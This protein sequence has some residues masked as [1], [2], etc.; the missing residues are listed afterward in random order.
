LSSR[1]TG[2]RTIRTQF[3]NLTR[4][5]KQDI[6]RL[7]RE[8]DNLPQNVSSKFY[9]DFANALNEKDYYKMYLTTGELKPGVLRR[10]ALANKGLS[11]TQNALETFLTRHNSGMLYK[12]LNS[13]QRSFRRLE[14]QARGVI[15]D[16][17][18]LR[19]LTT[20]QNQLIKELQEYKQYLDDPT[21]IKNIEDR[22]Q[23]ITNKQPNLNF[24]KP[25]TAELD[26]RLRLNIRNNLVNIQERLNQAKKIKNTQLP[27]TLDDIDPAI[28]QYAKHKSVIQS[29]LRRTNKEYYNAQKKLTEFKNTLKEENELMGISLNSF[30]KY[31]NGSFFDDIA[32]IQGKHAERMKSEMYTLYDIQKMFDSF[33]ATD[34]TEQSLYNQLSKVQQ[35]VSKKALLPQEELTQMISLKDKLGSVQTKWSLDDLFQLKADQERYIRRAYTSQVR[36]MRKVMHQHKQEL[37][38]L[39]AKEKKAFDYVRGKLL[40]ETKTTNAMVRLDKMLNNIQRDTVTDFLPNGVVS[41]KLNERAKQLFDEYLEVFGFDDVLAGTFKDQKI[42]ANNIV[43]ENIVKKRTLLLRMQESE[44]QLLKYLNSPELRDY[45]LPVYDVKR[46]VAGLDMST[47]E[48]AIDYPVQNVTPDF[49][50]K[51]LSKNAKLPPRRYNLTLLERIAGKT[52]TKN[53]QYTPQEQEL[54][55]KTGGVDKFITMLEEKTAVQ[56]ELNLL[57]VNNNSL[58]KTTKSK[59]D[60]LQYILRNTSIEI[61]KTKEG[62]F[63]IQNPPKRFDTL[64]DEHQYKKLVSTIGTLDNLDISQLSDSTKPT[65]NQIIARLRELRDKKVNIDKELYLAGFHKDA[66]ELNYF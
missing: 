16:S 52:K 34:F 9:D 22:I 7:Q 50:T 13:T 10:Q 57:K 63:Y 48:K 14:R 59:I 3:D 60:N 28:L 18:G 42:V 25:D 33:K 6:L 37:T 62:Y 20:K 54:L 41:R 45:K 11:Q 40:S 23:A 8:V 19:E 64:L 1:N 46:Y 4:R 43:A 49:L 15:K 61:G 65:Y 17:S 56:N 24:L 39:Y 36:N 38:G 5:H 32:A 66:K 47:L 35:I 31:D 29:E 51:Y 21:T 55:A 30:N 58:L 12:R 53:A 27:P 2:F 26:K 44:E